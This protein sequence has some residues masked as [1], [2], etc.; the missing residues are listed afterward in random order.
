MTMWLATAQA[1]GMAGGA[2]A[3]AAETASRQTIQRAMRM[4]TPGQDVMDG[5]CGRPQAYQTWPRGPAWERPWGPGVRTAGLGC[6]RG[7]WGAPPPREGRGGCGPG[8]YALAAWSAAEPSIT[9][10]TPFEHGQVPPTRLS[11]GIFMMASFTASVPAATPRSA[12][13]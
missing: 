2:R 3:A 9:Q 5:R 7:P 13:A 10:R 6:A 4:G 8:A 1:A 12:S 11:L